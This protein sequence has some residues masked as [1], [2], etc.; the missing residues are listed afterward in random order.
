MTITESHGKTHEGIAEL[1]N[2]KAVG[3]EVNELGNGK[4]YVSLDR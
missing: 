3:L 2:G 4:I 1:S